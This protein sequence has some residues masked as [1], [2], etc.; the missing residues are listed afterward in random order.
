METHTHAFFGSLLAHT[1]SGQ[2]PCTSFRLS[3]AAVPPA[4][5]WGK[6]LAWTPRDDAALL[7]GAYFHGLGH[8]DTVVNDERLGL[9]A[10]LG[11]VLGTASAAGEEEHG[12][13]MLKGEWGRS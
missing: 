3:S 5:K 2:D 12:P 7:L 13:V 8:W 10:K 11:S 4:P 1:G 9:K 6:A